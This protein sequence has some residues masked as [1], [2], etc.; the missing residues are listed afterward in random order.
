MT[1][2][3]PGLLRPR[4]PD[5]G[6]A[7]VETVELFYD[8]VFVFAITQLSHRLTHHPTL[9]GALETGL[10]FVALWWSWVYTAWA[11]NWLDPNRT[12]VRFLIFALMAGGLVVS[13]SIPEA[14]AER[15]AP[16][17]IAYV[18]I[19][20]TRS[21]FTALALRRHDRAN[22]VNFVRIL[23]WQVGCGAFWIAG[24]FAE[25]SRLALWAAGLALWSLAPVLYFWVPGLGASRASVWNV[26]AH[27]LAE[28]CGLFIIIALGESVLATGATFAEVEWTA[29]AAIAVL[30]A[31][32]GTVALWWVYFNIGAEHA[33][34]IFAASA[35]RGRVARLAYTYL[36]IPIVGGS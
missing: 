23:V 29:P 10:L 20:V 31:F 8:L 21:L 13:M 12:R 14:F 2:R 24:A 35:E 26:D 3:A 28:R 33:A 34:H 25:E 6:E 18:G 32:A 5:A 17:A 4:G 16:F 7:R 27:H 9:E 19:E 22:C 15:A 11:T 30:G 36:H 1:A